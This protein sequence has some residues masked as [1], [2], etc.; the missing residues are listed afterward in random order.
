MA[1][2][3]YHSVRTQ[4]IK[5][6]TVGRTNYI[7]RLDIF[8]N[9]FINRYLYNE[10]FRSSLVVSL[11]LGYVAKVEG[12]ANPLHGAK[13][14]IVMLELASGGN[15]KAFEYVSGNLKDI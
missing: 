8:L 4:L 3:F 13:V 14:L 5:A 2:T 11:M 1:A 10:Q 15:F 12:L 7:P 6:S 9:S